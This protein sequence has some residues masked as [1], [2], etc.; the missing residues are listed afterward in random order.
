MISKHPVSFTSA[1]GQ[2][3][4]QASKTYKEE[5]IASQDER[6]PLIFGE[7]LKRAR[8][9]FLE[10]PYQN[11]P[12]QADAKGDAFLNQVDSFCKAGQDV[13]DAED[14]SILSY[15]K[16]VLNL[17]KIEFPNDEPVL[18]S[19]LESSHT[20]F[21]DGM[22]QVNHGP[23]ATSGGF[24]TVKEGDSPA[25]I[26]EITIHSDSPNPSMK[27]VSPGRYEWKDANASTQLD[28][29][30]NSNTYFVEE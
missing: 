23:N 4:K 24:N 8:K 27:E 6:S 20:S 19:T 15:M 18:T 21:H 3:L 14:A 7:G 11:K 17:L 29:G 30:P 16:N 28:V 12:L 2:A 5:A 22:K 25:Y 9:A 26:G 1:A 10:E 13:Y